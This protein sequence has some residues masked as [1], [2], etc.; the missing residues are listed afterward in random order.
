MGHL[1][2]L[3]LL[4]KRPAA[5]PRLQ[6]AVARTGSTS[7]P[8]HA[9]AGPPMG[10]SSSLPPIPTPH[11][12][13][14]SRSASPAPAGAGGP[15]AAAA[16]CGEGINPGGGAGKAE[17]EQSIHGDGL[18]PSGRRR[19]LDGLPPAS[20]EEPPLASPFGAAAEQ[21][22]RSAAGSGADSD[23]D[24]AG[25]GEQRRSLE[26]PASQAPAPALPAPARTLGK[27]DVLRCEGVGTG[28]F[29]SPASKL[30]LLALECCGAGH[31]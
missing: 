16:A 13:P 14:H 9:P 20:A 17:V 29:G 8:P 25:G 3:V 1:A 19:S 4:M 2:L 27:Q 7:L 12:R 28:L 21:Q 15:A 24:S 5:V 30:H 23:G 6:E 26:L 18:P 11:S 22:V 31:E 10:R